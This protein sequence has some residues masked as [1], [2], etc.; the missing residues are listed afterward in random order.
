MRR[1]LT[2]IA[3]GLG[4]LVGL[5]FLSP[6]HEYLDTV[7]SL[8]LHLGLAAVAVLALALAARAWSAVAVSGAVAGL[9]LASLGPVWSGE[10]VMPGE[11]AISLL[12]INLS[13]SNT[14]PEAALAA[15]LAADADVLATIETPTSVVGPMGARLKAHYPHAAHQSAGPERL[16]T[17]IWS[18]FPLSEVTVYPNNTL[19]PIATRVT[20]S[21]PGRRPFGLIATH[22]ARPDTGR[23]RIQIAGFREIAAGARRPLVIAGDF[24]AVPWS[25]GMAMV[26]DIS[27]TALARGVRLS[28]DGQYRSPFG[29]L[30]FPV[31]LPIDHVLASPEI[32]FAAMQTVEIPGSD[33]QGV[34]AELVLSGL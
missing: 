22:F 29:T 14:A 15:M 12:S 30:N 7:S 24:N 27:E 20:V 19:V 21:P 33:H 28:W 11:R 31:G 23:Q 34:W 10:R 13:N 4:L 18:R 5:G 26:L 25:T 17:S 6:V 32:G 8:R 3:A 16:L 1:L 9:A 2:L